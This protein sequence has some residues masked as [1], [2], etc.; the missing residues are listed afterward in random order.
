M[1]PQMGLPHINKKWL[2]KCTKTSQAAHLRAPETTRKGADLV[3]TPMA[4][5]IPSTET[6]SETG[7]EV[8]RMCAE[9]DLTI[10][11]TME[12]GVIRT[13]EIMTGVPITE[14]SMVEILTFS[15]KECRG[16]FVGPHRRLA[17]HPSSPILG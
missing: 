4:V 10:T 8:A 14:A 17:R 16:L 15:S 7:T 3:I 2:V 5:E 6:R 1:H 9:T 12:A 11:T 13:V